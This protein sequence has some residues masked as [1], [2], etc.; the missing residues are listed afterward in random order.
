M[1]KTKRKEWTRE[2]RQLLH[3]MRQRGKSFQEIGKLLDRD[4]RVVKRAWKRYEPESPFTR[5][6]VAD[7]YERAKHDYEEHKKRLK[8]PKN[9]RRLG[10]GVIRKY[11]E[12][13]LRAGVTPELIAGRIE[14]ETGERAVCHETIYQWIYTERRELMKFLPLVSE[15]GR[16]KRSSQN[17]YRHREPAAP[18]R[19]ISERLRVVE[20]KDRF[21]DYERDTVKGPQG[22]K[23]CI[24]TIRERKGRIVMLE[25]LY[26]GTAEAAKAATI[27]RLK[28]FPK[29]LR[30]TMT[31]D[32]GSE[33]ALHAEEEKILEMT[34]YFCHPYCAP[35]R[36]SV[37][38]ANRFAVRRTFP[39][40]TDFTQVNFAQ[41]KAAEVWFNN[42]PM[43]CLGF[44]TPMEVFSKE[45]KKKGL[46]PEQ[47]GLKRVDP[48]PFQ[49]FVKEE[50]AALGG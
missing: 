47:V 44:H 12:A 20:N 8:K 46:T 36:G 9:R 16:R 17:Q 28:P 38:N 27:F 39:K 3:V 31:Q 19:S 23:P 42:R 13:Q 5:R 26:D 48:I 41:V 1:E 50:F 30:L 22:S 2:E 35:E 6:S 7:P 29:E 18:K 15:R 10:N 33:N 11:V 24:L 25:K 14:A 32:N 37:E 21:G 4:W 40:G 49:A 43:K 34:Q 45:L